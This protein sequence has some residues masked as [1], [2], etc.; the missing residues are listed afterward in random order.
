MRTELSYIQR[1]SVKFVS[2]NPTSMAAYWLV[3]GMRTFHSPMLV[4]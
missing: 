3:Q 4:I 1:R 2:E